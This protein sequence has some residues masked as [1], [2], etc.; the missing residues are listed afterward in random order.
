MSITLLDVILV[1]VLVEITRL[2][3]INVI[4]SLLVMRTLW[5]VTLLCYV[6]I[7]DALDCTTKEVFQSIQ[8]G[9]E[10]N[11]FIVHNKISSVL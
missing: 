10:M 2:Y 3:L 8:T 1:L 4:A 11:L 5:M 7:K 6:R 9:K